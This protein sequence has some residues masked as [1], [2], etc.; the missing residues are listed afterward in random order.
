M[1]DITHVLNLNWPE[2]GYLRLM[3]DMDNLKSFCV[4]NTPLHPLSLFFFFWVA[5]TLKLIGKRM[6]WIA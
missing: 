2:V 1:P 3:V 4:G 6:A 5:P